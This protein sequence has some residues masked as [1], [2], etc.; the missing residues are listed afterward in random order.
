[1]ADKQKR[2]TRAKYWDMQ[3]DPKDQHEASFEIPVM[4]H[5]LGSDPRTEHP[6]HMYEDIA[7]QPEALRDTFNECHEE[8]KVLAKE[9]VE[10]GVQR[11]VGTGLG[12]SQFVM[13]AAAGAFWK[14]AGI[15]AN[16]IDG[17]EYFLNPRPYD[18]SK[19]VFAVLS[20][21]G[22]TTDSNRAG[23]LAKEKGAFVLAFTS[24]ADSPVTKF[25]DRTI[26]TCGGFDTGGGDTFHYT[27]R[28]YALILLAV[29]MGRLSQPNAYDY[30]ALIVELSA[31]PER[32]VEMYEGVEDRCRSI[33]KQ[34]WNKRAVI[35]VGNGS[36]YGAAEE[37]GL[38]YDEMAHLPSKAMVLDRHIHGALG[39]TDYDILT[40]LLAPKKD[41]G[42]KELKD[43]AEHCNIIKTLC[44]GIVSS[45]DDDISNIVDDVIRIP[46]ETPEFFPLLAILPGQLIPYYSSIFS[47]KLNPD[48][49]RSNVVRYGKA[50]AKLFP[51]GTH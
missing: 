37:M 32:F 1:M 25:A 50:W 12:T 43:I 3:G 21:S 45:E 44:V 38:K 40:I 5:W 14:F 24:I 49:Q 22:S 8:I 39:L 27:T 6:Y 19:T 10:R 41:P 9:L 36:N 34:Y 18:F 23:K 31:I 28:T 30:D 2:G 26:V 33:S 46:C 17:L 13:Q 51:P 48:T 11:I 47:G 4:Y 7:T 15:D 35:I 42:Y 16:D 29:E 20:G